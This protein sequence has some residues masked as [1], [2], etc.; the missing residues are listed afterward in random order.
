MGCAL[1]IIEPYFFEENEP[2]VKSVRMLEIVLK[3]E[4]RRRQIPLKG[5]WFKKDG[6]TF[7]DAV[8]QFLDVSWPNYLMF[9]QCCMA[10]QVSQLICIT[11]FLRGHLK[12]C[13]YKHKPRNSEELNNVIIQEIAACRDFSSCDG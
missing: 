12:N 3:P 11:F 8:R 2:S 1:G 5:V 7:L 9:W 6:A 4:L 13:V 10:S